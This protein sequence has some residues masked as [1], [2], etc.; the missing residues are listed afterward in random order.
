MLGSERRDIPLRCQQLLDEWKIRLGAPLE[1]P[2]DVR[3]GVRFYQIRVP[4]EPHVFLAENLVLWEQGRHLGIV[5]EAMVM[6]GHGMVT[7]VS[8][9]DWRFMATGK[10]VSE[11]IDVFEQIAEALNWPQLDAVLVC[12]ATQYNPDVLESVFNK[13]RF[14]YI[15]AGSTVTLKNHVESQEGYLS[16]WAFPG[17]G[18]R[19]LIA[20]AKKW[21]EIDKWKHFWGH[22][23]GIRLS[24]TIP[25]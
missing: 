12:R 14:P 23:D 22:V 3:G 16:N 24:R 21:F 5:Q 19:W 10:R 17:L 7:G 1:F 2:D 6:L 15:N 13:S 25:E 8:S 11:T 18:V 4:F 9:A 20:D